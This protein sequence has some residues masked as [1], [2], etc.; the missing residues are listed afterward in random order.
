MKEEIL[1]LS[2]SGRIDVLP[3]GVVGFSKYSCYEEPDCKVSF[4]NRQS[5]LKILQNHDVAKMILQTTL[6]GYSK[7]KKAPLLMLLD[8]ISRITVDCIET[9]LGKTSLV[10]PVAQKLRDPVKTPRF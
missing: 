6:F 7:M 5:C 4:S 9:L 1:E 10:V 3:E 8:W 2:P